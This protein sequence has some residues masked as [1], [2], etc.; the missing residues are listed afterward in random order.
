MLDAVPSG[1]AESNE[2]PKAQKLASALLCVQGNP[3]GSEERT[4]SRRVLKSG[5]GRCLRMMYT[6]I[7]TERGCN[8]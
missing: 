1:R 6:A 3:T 2:P 7:D 8:N 5:D 4:L